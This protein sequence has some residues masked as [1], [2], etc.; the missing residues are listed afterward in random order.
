MC[1]VLTGLSGNLCHSLVVC[2]VWDQLFGVVSCSAAGRRFSHFSLL[3]L[4]SHEDGD[5]DEEELVRCS[6]SNPQTQNQVH[7]QFELNR[8]PSTAAPG[9]KGHPACHPPKSKR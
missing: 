3:R 5:I 7:R 8:W 9:S 6:Q 4:L 1:E 2:T